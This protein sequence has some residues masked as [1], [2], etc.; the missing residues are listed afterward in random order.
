MGLALQNHLGELFRQSKIKFDAQ[1]FT[2][3][4]KRPDFLFPGAKQYHDLE[5]SASWLTM[6][7]AKSSCKE[8]WPQVLPEADRIPVKHL[9]TLEPAISEAQTDEMHRKGVVLVLPSALHATYTASQ[10]RNLMT[11]A[12]FIEIVKAKQSETGAR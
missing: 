1:A 8:R 4:R 2:E 10:R 12:G 11:L 7:A 9:C 3:N 5:F 6:L